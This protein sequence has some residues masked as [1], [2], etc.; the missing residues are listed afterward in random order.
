VEHP[1]RSGVFKG[2]HTTTMTK[3][4]L[5]FGTTDLGHMGVVVIA[6]LWPV[7]ANGDDQDTQM[8]KI[9]RPKNER[10]IGHGPRLV[11]FQV[12]HPEL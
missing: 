1:G 5:I 8:T 4:A 6:R 10:D 12:D 11:H 3:I 7:A 9:G 2:K